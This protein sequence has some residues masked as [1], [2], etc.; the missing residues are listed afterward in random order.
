MALFGKDKP[1]PAAMKTHKWLDKY[2]LEIISRENVFSDGEKV[3]PEIVKRS[4][5]EMVK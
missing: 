3:T 4:F 5:D 2:T 1:V